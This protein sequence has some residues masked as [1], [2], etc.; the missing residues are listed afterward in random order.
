MDCISCVNNSRARS[1][2]IYHRLDSAN[3]L[4]VFVVETSLDMDELFIN[5]TGVKRLLSHIV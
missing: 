3:D 5:S 2:N 1:R 4:N